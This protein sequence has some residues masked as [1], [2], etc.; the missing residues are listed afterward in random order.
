MTTKLLMGADEHVRFSLSDKILTRY[1]IPVLLLTSVTLI[2]IYLNPDSSNSTSFLLYFLV[3]ILSVK[4]CGVKPAFVVTLLATAFCLYFFIPGYRSFSELFENIFQILLFVAESFLIIL[5]GRNAKKSIENFRQTEQTFK[6]FVEK[7]GHGFAIVNPKGK[8][9]YASK[10]AAEML[11]YTPE[12]LKKL[13]P[14][15]Y[16]DHNQQL[17]LAGY[18]DQIL[19]NNGESVQYTHKYKHKNGQWLWLET[20]LTNHLDEPG[21]NAIT[22]NFKNVTDKILAEQQREDF[23]NIASHEL[24]SP[25]SY[26]NI[27]TSLIKKEAKG[28]NNVR[29][30]NIIERMQ[31]QLDK[32]NKVAKDLMDVQQMK[33]G[34]VEYNYS[35]FDFNDLILDT[36]ASSQIPTTHKINTYVASLP[37]ILADKMRIK[38]VIV[39]LISNA[40]RYSPNANMIKVVSKSVGNFLRFEVIDNGIGITKSD[41]EDVFQRFFRAKENPL[42]GIG[43]GLYIS[44]QIVKQHGGTIGFDSEKDKG[45]VFWFTLPV[46]KSPSF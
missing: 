21:I 20:T 16:K 7:N 12:E 24:Q 22:C 1:S 18:Y 4:F 45:S 32:T 28:E 33:D 44:A 23:I 39:N 37:R 3:V 10:T 34:N 43:L 30:E 27:Y 31:I 14:D 25:L 46:S 38:Q 5:L 42:S 35:Y 13:H 26:L 29:L 40:I 19:D 6:T 36:V 15:S 2:N 11:G 9:I 17:E 41:H 8:L